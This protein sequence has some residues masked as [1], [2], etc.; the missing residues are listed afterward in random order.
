MLAGLP[1]IGGLIE[2]CIILLG[3]CVT[4]L[5]MGLSRNDVELRPVNF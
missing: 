1:I 3:L 5:A 2:W 4:V